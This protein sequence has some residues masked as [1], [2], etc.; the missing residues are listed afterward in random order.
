M[1]PCKF[2]RLLA[3]LALGSPLV[4]PILGFADD[5]QGIPEAKS[6]NI[7]LDVNLVQLPVTVTDANGHSVPGLS[8]DAFR[9]LV[10]GKPQPITVFQGEDAPVTAGIVLD[11]SASMEAKKAE[12][13]VA[14]L[15]FARGS[16][17]LDQMFVVHF[18]DHSRLGLP[19]QTPFTGEISALE[20][21]ISR[22][23]LGG[24]TALYD[25]LMFAQLQFR[26]AVYT[27]R[28]LLIITDGADN[29]STAN[30]RDVVVKAQK[31]GVTLFTIGMFEENDRSRNIPELT[32][33]A[34]DTGGRAFFPHAIADITQVC[35]EI[36]KEIRREYTLG[37]PGAED[38]SYHH[39]DVTAEDPR[40]GSLRVQTRPGYFAQ[41]P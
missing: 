10:D 11:N 38:G 2:A 25:A 3:L 20:Q 27:R 40:F 6:A 31:A 16:N 26:Q 37:F 39:I 29:S 5:Q 33:L 23:D 13:I 28:V 21:A 36:A 15:A 7:R 32:Q 18:S 34:A 4:I 8:K 1:E 19:P 30:L 12:V 14:A 35:E 22:F 24:T 17:P 9:V 41:N